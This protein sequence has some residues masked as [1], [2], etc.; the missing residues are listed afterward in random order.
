M[1]DPYRFD[2]PIGQ[3]GSD[4]ERGTGMADALITNTI[5]PEIGREFLSRLAS[6]TAVNR[7]DSSQSN[8]DFAFAFGRRPAFDPKTAL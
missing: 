7:A 4:L 5:L 2:M 6:S 1:S 3:R 8:K